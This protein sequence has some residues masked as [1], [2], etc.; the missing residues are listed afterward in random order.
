V[1]D[2][3]TNADP[4]HWGPVPEV[5]D[6]VTNLVPHPADVLEIGPGH[7]PFGRATEFVDIRPLDNLPGPLH[8]CDLSQDKLPFTD[9]FFDFVYCR[10]VLED[11]VNPFLLCREMQRVGKAG[12]IETPSPLAEFCRGVDGGAPPWRGYHHHRWMI[13]PENDAL[14][15]V[16]KFPIVEHLK[17][18]DKAAWFHVLTQPIYWNSYFLWTDEIKVR[19][20][21]CPFDFMITENYPSVISRGITASMAASAALYTKITGTPPGDIEWPS[22]S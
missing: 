9:K 22:K 18:D 11:M 13:W 14:N 10:H 2:S 21:E 8:V 3:L 7:I 5:I 12:Y 1:N 19:H 6:Y 20:W 15:F 16:S 4:H 17:G